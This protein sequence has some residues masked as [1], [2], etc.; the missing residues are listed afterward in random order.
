VTFGIASAAH[1]DTESF[2][3]ET[4][5]QVVH[6]PFKSV[7]EALTAMLAGRVDFGI[8]ALSSAIPPH[9]S[10]KAKALG[11]LGPKRTPALPDV[12]TLNEIGLGKFESGGMFAFYVPTGTPQ[13][14][15]DKI[16]ADTNK[17]RSGEFYQQKVLAAN[18]I[19]DLPLSGA[20][21]IKRFDDSRGEFLKRIKG[22]K[23]ELQ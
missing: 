15:M 16:A 11:Y 3:R 12:P 18:G 9:K 6:V 22:L 23:L 13:A 14:V 5:I 7:T 8:I 4:G 2:A 1:F 21:L 20:A 17:A 19:E 10:G